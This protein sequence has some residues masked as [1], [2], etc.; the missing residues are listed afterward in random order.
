MFDS[1]V[2]KY[3]LP[4][5]EEPKGYKNSIEFQ[6][7]DLE[8][9]LLVYEIR[10][11]GSLWLEEHER[12]YVPGDPKA[13]FFMD[14][15]GRMKIIRSWLTQQKITDTIEIYDYLETSSEYDYWIS[16]I[17]T[18]IDGYIK[19]VKLKEFRASN[20]ANRINRQH[21][22]DLEM[23]QRHE[24]QKTKRYRYFYK[25]HNSFVRFIF[26]RFNKMIAFAS[27]NINKIERKLLV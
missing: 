23:R 11:D 16:Y 12:E 4:M 27:T 10:E 9:G 1:V 2:C 7:K 5:P 14:R 13:K 24:F 6:T 15:I 18:F 25:H 19:D 8:N 3:A 21:Q 17:I 20:N 22:F 26:R